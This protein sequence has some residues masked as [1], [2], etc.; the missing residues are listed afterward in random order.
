MAEAQLGDHAVVIGGSMAGLLAAAVLTRHFRRVTIVERDTFPV[1]PAPRKGVPQARHIHLMLLGG[2]SALRQLLPGIDSEIA[3]AGAPS[4]DFTQD[5]GLYSF[6]I[7]APRFRS[8]LIGYSCTRDLLEYCVRRR[9]T[10]LRGLNI[11]ERCDVVGLQF[12]PGNARVTGV[13][14]RP[15]PNNDDLSAEAAPAD[16]TA[17]LL[18]SD[19]VIDASGRG[20]RLPSWLTGAGYAAPEVTDINSFLGYASR[21][22]RQPANFTADWSA[23]VVRATPPGARGAALYPIEG[24]HWFVTLAGAARDYPPTDEAGFVDFLASLP[25]PVIADA[26]R[27]AEPLTPIAGYRRTAN[28]LRHYERLRDWPAGLV[29]I[30]DAV[31]AFNPVYGQGMSA[32]ARAA[33]ALDECLREQQ[34][35]GR[36]ITTIGLHFQR[37]LARQNADPWLMAT[38]EDFRYP[39]TEGG[40]PDRTTR[41]MH[42]YMDRLFARTDD[43]RVYQTIIEV[44]HL[45]RPPTALFHPALIA[46]SLRPIRHTEMSAR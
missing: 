29:A 37:Q 39:T 45:I 5:V 19:L 4:F 10:A 33:I 34:R 18:T 28:Q 6:G 14:L 36:D 11:V 43:Q 12:G 35:H 20:S 22:Y 41:L 44:L 1:G 40:R 13:R 30:G 38:G 23:I 25:D 8:N 31:C 46:E 26:L 32:A 24:G 2:Q 3:A 7:W 17:D 16:A 9:V 27:T 15:R 21:I 42:R